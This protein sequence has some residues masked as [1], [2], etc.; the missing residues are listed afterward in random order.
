MKFKDKLALVPHKPGSYQ[1]K[2]KNGN[3]IYVGKAKDLNKRLSSY[4]NRVHTGKT[5]KMV[6]LIEDFQYIVAS[7]EL[8]AFIIEINLIK[9]FNPKYNIMLTDDK[10]YPY[11]EYISDPYPKLKVSRYLNIRKKDGKKLFGPYPNAY[12]ARRIVNLLNRLYPLKKCEGNP[13]EVCLY[14][15]IGE[16]LGYCSNK[17]DKDKIVDMENEILSFLRGND[18]ILRNKIMDKITKY[19]ENLNFEMAL[20]LKKELEYI[21][22]VLDKQKVELHDFVNRDVISYFVDNGYLSIEILFIRNGKLLNHKNEI[23]PINLDINDDI[24]YYI[25][26]FYSRNEIPKEILIPDSLNIENLKSVVNT[27]FIIP[28]KGVKKDLLE[29]AFDNAKLNLNNRF[30]EIKKDEVMTSKANDELAKIL[31][32]DSI[33][34][35]DVFDNSNL[36]GSFAVSGMVVFIDGKP[37]K[38]EY[39]KYKVSVDVNDDYNTMKEILYRRYQRALVDK[40]SLPELIIV[41]GG[42]NQIRAAKEILELLHLNIMVVGLKKNDKH[43]TNDLISSDLS[44][45]NI[46]RMSNVFHYLTRMQDEVHRFTINYHRTLRSKGSISS[47]LDDIEGIGPV[48]KKQLIKKFGSI[49]K[50]R[51]ATLQ[52]VEEILPTNVAIELKEYLD[53]KYNKE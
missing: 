12:A 44:V 1:M 45:I 17:I 30:E 18:E 35:I 9:E 31:G 28:Q 48:R 27:N 5:A 46:D 13:K 42:E 50:M 34:R 10:S 20:D 38:N 24:E 33:Y 36:F 23:F 7:S 22:I 51:E 53:S 8:E 52:E 4:F 14:Y 43:R 15:H 41:D 47:V 26:K 39:R 25:A 32:L 49:A 21:D 11:I 2:D 37:A 3:I 19:S 16:C 40:T 29:M 6:S